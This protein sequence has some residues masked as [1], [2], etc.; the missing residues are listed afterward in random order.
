MMNK[1]SYI[2]IFSILFSGCAYNGSYESTEPTQLKRYN[3]Y[4]KNG[5]RVGTIKEKDGRLEVYDKNSHRVGTI[6]ER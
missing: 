4:D 2:I 5:H 3:I 6:I 1:L